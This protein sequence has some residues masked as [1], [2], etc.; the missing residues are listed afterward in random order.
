MT[1]TMIIVN[2]LSMAS[3]DG[4]LKWLNQVLL[5]SMEGNLYML[6]APV[7]APWLLVRNHLLSAKGLDNIGQYIFSV[8]RMPSVS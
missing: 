4:C 2:E 5:S 3:H 8:I 1:I 6:E 7:L